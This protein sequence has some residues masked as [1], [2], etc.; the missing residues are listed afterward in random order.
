MSRAEAP[1]L[2]KGLKVFEKNGR[3]AKD[4][5]VGIYGFRASQVENG[6]K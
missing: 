2:S 1:E 6:V 3:P 4:F 5:V